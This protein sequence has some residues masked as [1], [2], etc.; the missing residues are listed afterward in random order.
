MRHRASQIVNRELQD[1]WPQELKGRRKDDTDEAEEK[2]TA[3]AKDVWKET[4]KRGAHLIE[5]IGASR[6]A[7]SQEKREKRESIN[8]SFLSFLLFKRG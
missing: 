3:I 2:L 5:Y 1:P 8:L 6:S 4:A 7:P